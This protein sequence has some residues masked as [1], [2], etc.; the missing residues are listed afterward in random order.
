MYLCSLVLASFLF[1]S[2]TT[3][4]D[5]QFNIWVMKKCLFLRAGLLAF[6]HALASEPREPL[7]VAAFAL[8]VHNGGNLSEAIIIA[9][10]ITH[11]YDSSYPEI[12]EPHEERVDHD[13]INEVLDLAS[14][15]KSSLIMMQDENYIS[16]AMSE[17]A[18]APYSN[19]AS[20]IYSFILFNSV[21]LM[22]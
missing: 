10:G 11:C 18:D 15:V 19:L 17:Y 6:H 5:W 3:K 21:T 13:L 1:S 22:P 12:L 8:A 9:K 14:A 20:T 16:Q 7:V 4:I 2:S